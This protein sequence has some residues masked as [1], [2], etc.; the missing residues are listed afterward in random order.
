MVET[1]DTLLETRP[2]NPKS[3]VKFPEVLQR[4]KI[5]AS[6]RARK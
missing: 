3:T 6:F 1:E 2:S 4:K 5:N